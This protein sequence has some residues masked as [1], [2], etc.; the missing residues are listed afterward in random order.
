MSILVNNFI[1]NNRT[2]HIGN[3]ASYV[4][5]PRLTCQDGFSMS[6]QASPTHYSTP[7]DIVDEYTAV[8]I[9]YPSQE[10]ELILEWA[11]DSDNPTGTVYG[12]VPVEVVE[13]VILNHG[14]LSDS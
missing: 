12:W 9:G 6:V 7:R 3:A 2:V 5:C 8:E 14:G 13:Q 4:Q 10:E 1:I 11:E